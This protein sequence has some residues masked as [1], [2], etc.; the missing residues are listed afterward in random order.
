MMTAQIAA[1]GRLGRDPRQHETASGKA[2]TTASLAVTVQ[3]RERGA[4]TGRRDSA[5]VRACNHL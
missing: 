2:L 5:A 1:H 3:A 4:V